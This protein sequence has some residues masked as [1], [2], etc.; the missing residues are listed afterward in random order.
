MKKISFILFFS[1]IVFASNAQLI[2]D[3]ATIA[4]MK[5]M[6]LETKILAKK[7]ADKLFDVY[8]QKL[9]SDEKQ[10]LTFLF[11]YM[12]LSDLADYNGQ[13][14][15]DN[16]KMALLAR[17]EMWW[18][19]NIPE[20]VFLHFVLPVR[21]N[22]ENLDSL[23][24]KMY[25][26]LKKRVEG[27]SMKKAALEV[28]HWCHEKVT[29][30]ASDERTSSPLSSIKYSFG[31]C[32]EESTF[33]V[34]AL[35]TIGIPARQ[36]YTPRWAHTDDNHAWVE[37]WVDGK[38]YFLGAC[39]PEP[40]LNMGWFAN[41]AARAMLVH[42]RA[43]GWYH[44]K[45]EVLTQNSR[46]SELNL[47]SNYAPVKYFAVKVLDENGKPV[48]K[49]QVEYQVYNYAEFYP[50]AKT[51]TDS[52]GITG[53]TT[54]L[55]DLL[56]WAS[57]GDACG[58]KKITVENT[59]TVKIKIKILKTGDLLDEFDFVPPVERSVAVAS[60]TGVKEN[61]K[62]L[63]SEDSLRSLYMATFRDSSWIKD[64]AVKNN[65]NQD[66][67][68][69]VVTKSSG[70]WEEI[71]SFLKNAPAEK[72]HWALK[73]LTALS[74]KDLRDAN[75]VVLSDHL[76]N[77]FKYDNGLSV[78]DPELFTKYILSGRV[79]YEWMKGWRSY[80]QKEFGKSF[81]LSAQKDITIITDWIKNNITLDQT[82]N[83]HSRAPLTP[84]GVYE[85]GV[86]DNKSRDI[87]FVALCRSLGIPA[88]LNPETLYPEYWK[89]SEWI[90]IPFNYTEAANN[91]NGYIH[92]VNANQDI[93]PKY[94]Q[95]FTIESFSNGVYQTLQYDESKSLYDF[96]KKMEVGTGK[97]LLV[98]GNRQ[99]DGSVL[100]SM[101]FFNVYL[102]KTVELKV[103]VREKP[104]D[105]KP[106]GKI[107]T[108]G[109]ILNGYSDSKKYLLS[110]M[111]KDTGAV[112]AFIDPD[113]EPSKHILVDIS[114]VKQSFEKLGVNII[115]VVP[116]K[117]KSGAFNPLVYKDIPKKSIFVADSK[118]DDFFFKIE[119]QKG[120]SLINK[121]PVVFYVNHKG[122]IYYYSEGYTIGIGEQLL[123]VISK[124]GN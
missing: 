112:I 124:K 92:L 118:T 15:L 59:D 106:L 81:A 76:L 61:T 70:N 13:F 3:T 30:K 57:H 36:V 99:T 103:N 107:D 73:L 113:K 49:A 83:L 90:K 67:T 77:A 25:D 22:N 119:Q 122:E 29:Y 80:L 75:A 108:S 17:N 51:Y 56:V 63:Q 21:V 79:G 65:L 38:W 50:L 62:R 54:G 97:Y 27:L 114:A 64:F 117:S 42:T 19:K 32:G 100:S 31:R 89:K 7:R 46:F 102:N 43:Y 78:S 47:I 72:R 26:E 2:S 104:V 35:R 105:E 94:M 58:Y 98:T 20:D 45:E 91:T 39:E 1:L 121:Y 5:K 93:E 60:E 68:L 87:F 115:F 14:F 116:G 96:P 44:G 82:T 28:N 86:A 53:I 18:G 37:V 109:I 101:F 111:L 40:D 66:T 41:P 12:P 74:D 88:R 95:N 110:E 48:N 34:A 84:I 8:K 52:S 4:H 10:A 6:F 24:I 23:R 69:S 55:G 85:L 71:T 11:A 120:C 9:S 33:T 16:V 123:K